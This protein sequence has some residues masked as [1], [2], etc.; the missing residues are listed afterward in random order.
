M[1]CCGLFRT[2]RWITAT[3]GTD[4]SRVVVLADAFVAQLLQPISA[5]A[6]FT[7]SL[8]VI[9]EVF[10]EDTQA[11]TGAV[12]NMNSQFGGALGLGIMQIISTLVEK[13]Q[14]SLRKSDGLLAGYR[15]SFW[16]M[17][18]MMMLCAM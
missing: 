13:R 5:D 10:P 7:V 2:L 14:S 9:T 15:A 6:L 1:D 16:A 17:F 18:G 11:L 4:T 3:N 12:F 8:I